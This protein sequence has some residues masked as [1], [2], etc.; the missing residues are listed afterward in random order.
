MHE[1]G[2]YKCYRKKIIKCLQSS[3]TNVQLH[4]VPA[5]SFD[6]PLYNCN[7][8]HVVL[9]LWP[10]TGCKTVN[11]DFSFLWENQK[12]DPPQNENSYYDWD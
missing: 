1:P 9:S 11:N 5:E 7:K 10:I 12:F 3:K 6:T 8:I 2:L 4:A